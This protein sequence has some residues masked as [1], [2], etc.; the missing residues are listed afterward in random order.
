[1]VECL[2]KPGN[3]LTKKK[4][5]LQTKIKYFQEKI[6]DILGKK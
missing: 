5:K 4:E 1:M 2:R 6:A 3:K